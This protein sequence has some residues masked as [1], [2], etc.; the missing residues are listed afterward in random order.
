MHIWIISK[1]SL[2]TKAMLKMR[3]INV[4][5]NCLFCL[6]QEEIISQLCKDCLVISAK[7]W[8]LIKVPEESLHSFTID[9]KMRLKFNCQSKI[10]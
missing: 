4:N 10:T 8:Q 9:I 3:G 6:N 7:V 5:V 1:E 2:L